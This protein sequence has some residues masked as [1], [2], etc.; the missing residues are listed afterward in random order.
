MAEKLYE[1]LLGVFTNSAP[2][3][4]ALAREYDVSRQTIRRHYQKFLNKVPIEESKSVGRPK[5]L[6]SGDS[7]AMG[8]YIRQERDITLK[9]L[10]DKLERE[11]NVKVSA[12]TIS[13]NL[14]GKTYSK[15]PGRKAAML[16]T[17]H[18]IKRV[19]FCR[20]NKKRN[21]KKVIFSDETMVQ[22]G[23]SGKLIWVKRGE[24]RKIPAMKYPQKVMVWCAISYKGSPKMKFVQGTLKAQGY[25]ELLTTNL[26]PFLRAPGNRDLVY[27]EDNAPC[28]KAKLVKQFVEAKKIQILDWPPNS[29]DLNPIEN[30]WNE[31]K[32]RVEKYKPKTREELKSAIIKSWAEIEQ[33]KI[34]CY[35]DSMPRRVEACLKLKG[36]LTKY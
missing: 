20:K 29:P 17:E 28:H 11:R 25:K 10:Q 2:N 9:D 31:L 19:A 12:R 27:M 15:K 34:D 4:S 8:Q 22:I 36:G 6:N 35:L 5:K 30:L 1:K 24:S 14:Q 23:G 7:I 21:W 32:K 26:L 16:T 13:R 18:K 33:Q 3:F